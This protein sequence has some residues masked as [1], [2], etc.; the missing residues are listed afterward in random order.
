MKSILL[1]V[2]YI[3]KWPFWFDVY[4][5]SI[6]K[7]PTVNWLFITDCEIPKEHPEN[8][9]FLRT[10]LEQLNLKINRALEIRVPLSPRKLCDIRPAYGKI[11]QDE[12]KEYD[13]WG[14]CDVDI[15][16]GDIRAF[17]SQDNL[18]EYDIVSSRKH[19][20]SGHFTI[21]K[22]NKETNSLYKLI[23]K[24]IKKLEMAK[25]QRMDEDGL[26]EFLWQKLDGSSDLNLK[27]KW[28]TILC[29]QEK[30]RDSH[31]EY[32]LDKWLWKDGKMLELKSG[33]PVNEVMY[34][35]FINW[36]RTMK[37]CEVKYSDNPE[38]FYI[39]YNGMHFKPHSRFE[40]GWNRFKNLF[41]GYYVLVKRI[42]LK[43]KIMKL[44]KRV[45][46]R[47]T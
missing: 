41:D 31:Q 24:F 44:K 29:N 2:P 30:G 39:S 34:L 1:I 25:L 20:T 19:N 5:I 38:Q 22:N 12:I 13:F 45:I 14:F 23:P 26:T 11:F 10:T 3:G 6:A 8:V 36:K 4:L 46:R 27:V 15:V 28:S 17:V 33:E 32:H 18:I 35:H 47:I 21:F 16:W 7:N 9:K 37:F 43:K 40:K 42:R